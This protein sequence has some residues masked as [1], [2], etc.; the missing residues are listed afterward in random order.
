MARLLD[1]HPTT[2]VGPPA[3]RTA[4]E[5]FNHWDEVPPKLAASAPSGA[6]WVQSEALA[7]TLVRADHVTLRFDRASD[8]VYLRTVN[9]HFPPTPSPSSP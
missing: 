2:E 9:L 7:Q 1:G 5:A 3:V 4:A 6:S 8:T